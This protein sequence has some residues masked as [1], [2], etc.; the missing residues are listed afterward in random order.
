VSAEA[1]IRKLLDDVT[2][3]LRAKDVDRLLSHYAYDNVSFDLAPPLQHVGAAAQ[4][5]GLDAWFPTFR[6]P[7]GYETR[8][9]DIT[10]SEELAF[11]RSLNRIS[12]SRTNGEETD[13]WVRATLC[14]RKL[15]GEWKI[16][17]EHLSVPFYMDGSERA[18]TNLT[19]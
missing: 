9:V 8:D 10:A 11:C 6:G 5:K 1:E 15:D 2:N 4:R 13:V 14:F 7:V 17:Q 3:A 18:A 12:G 19:P 16:V